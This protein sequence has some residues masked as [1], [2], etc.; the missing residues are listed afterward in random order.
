MKYYKSLKE[1]TPAQDAGHI[2]YDLLGEQNGC[3]NGCKTGISIYDS[4]EYGKPGVHTD[5]EGF[6]VIEG[7]GWAR[8]G[9]QEVRLEADVSFIAPAGVPHTIKRDPESKHVKVFWFHSAV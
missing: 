7:T 5:Q 4:L 2:S 6:L 8:L 3:V 9:D 1:A